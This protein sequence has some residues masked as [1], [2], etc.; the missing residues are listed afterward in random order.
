MGTHDV[1]VIDLAANRVIATIPTGPN[2]HEVAI[3][4]D[5]RFVYVS[6]HSQGSVAAIEVATNRVIATIPV[7]QTPHDLS[8]SPNTVH[9]MILI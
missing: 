3:T 1:S 9:F 5:G 6:N 8:V 4:P 2:A 7:G